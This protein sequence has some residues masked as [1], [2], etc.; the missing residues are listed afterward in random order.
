MC[1]C[2]KYKRYKIMVK[3]EDGKIKKKEI[4]KYI[5][6]IEYYRQVKKENCNR[7]CIVEMF[8]I[9]QDG[10]INFM[11]GKRF[12]EQIKDFQ[13]EAKKYAE[14]DTY[15]ILKVI[16]ENIKLLTKREKYLTSKLNVINKMEDVILHQIEH[17]D[18]SENQ[19]DI[20]KKIKFDELVNVRKERRYIKTELF[21][22]GIIK[23][24][25][26]LPVKSVDFA[27]RRISGVDKGVN[28]KVKYLD[29]DVLEEKKIFKEKSYDNLIQRDLMV[30]KLKKKYDVVVVDDCRAKIYAYNKANKVKVV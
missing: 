12:E 1:K 3:F 18:L 22:L 29:N 26:E 20:A 23:D 7:S 24:S 28:E 9:T 8:G 14:T 27:I 11:F 25:V 5:P 13:L 10:Q 17:F 4:E 16:E 19:D 21:K 6:A 2:R 30:E 15:D